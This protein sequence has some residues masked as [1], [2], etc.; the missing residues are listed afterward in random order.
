[1]IRRRRDAGKQAVHESLHEIIRPEAFAGLEGQ[2]STSARELLGCRQPK[3]PAQA[4]RDGQ[5]R[6]LIQALD[7]GQDDL[8]ATGRIEVMPQDGL[9]D[10]LNVLADL[11]GAFQLGWRRWRIRGGL[12]QCGGDQNSAHESGFQSPGWRAWCNAE[13]LEEPPCIP[14]SQGGKKTRVADFPPLAKGG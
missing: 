8:L 4:G 14:P 2:S 11:T 12:P 9:S 7:S 10:V 6:G 1:M 5:P 13:A 3:T